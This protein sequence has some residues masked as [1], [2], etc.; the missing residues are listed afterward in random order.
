MEAQERHRTP[1]GAPET[2]RGSGRLL[3]VVLLFVTT[4]ILALL[5]LLTAAV[6]GLSLLTGSFIAST[7]ILGGFFAL[8]AAVVY[9]AVLREE[10]ERLRARAETV[11]EVARAARSGYEWLASK[12]ALLSRLGDALRRE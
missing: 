10:V 7:L 6:V 3:L 4:A 1:G 2:G 8:M 5:L 9:L 11:Y 12:V